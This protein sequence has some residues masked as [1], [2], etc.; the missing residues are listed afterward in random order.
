MLAAL[1]N[2]LRARATRLVE[3]FHL[4]AAGWFHATESVPHLAA[5]A[6]AVWEAQRIT[7]GYRRAG[8]EGAGA[9]DHVA[10]DLGEAVVGGKLAA[11]VPAGLQP[12]GHGA[13]MRH[14][15]I[16][17]IELGETASLLGV[18]VHTGPNAATAVRGLKVQFQRDGQWVDIPS[19]NVLNNQSTSLALAFDDT[20]AVR[21]NR[22]RLWITATPDGYARITEVVVWPTS[23][24]TLPPLAS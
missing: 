19:A 17:E 3:R 6:D 11:L 24:R 22:L 9:Q 21:T 23:V 16:L 1:P 4:D 12:L 15:E 20:V 18:H 10:G 7:V 5:I 13:H 14:A 8:V 2:E